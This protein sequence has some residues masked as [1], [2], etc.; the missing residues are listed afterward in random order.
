[1]ALGAVFGTA[2]DAALVAALGAGLAAGLAVVLLNEGP[3]L[4]HAIVNDT[5]C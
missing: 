3:I 1:V 4:V 2:L 5:L